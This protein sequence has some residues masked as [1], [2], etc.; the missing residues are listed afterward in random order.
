MRQQLPLP[1]LKGVQRIALLCH[2]F[3]MV[4][5]SMAAAM[6]T[7]QAADLLQQVPHSPSQTPHMQQ[8]TILAA[9]RCLQ[10]A[11]GVETI[12]FGERK[13]LD[14][15]KEMVPNGPDCSIEAVG[16]HYASTV[17]HK[18]R[19]CSRPTMGWSGT[20]HAPSAVMFAACCIGWRLPDACNKVKVQ[21]TGNSACSNEAFALTSNLS[22]QQ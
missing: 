14:A 12:N 13:T 11:P 1:W 7:L 4:L 21:G 22:H 18:V 3:C 10:V 5:P 16:F 6:H 17:L 2:P 8:V 19:C 9:S 20:L 15:L